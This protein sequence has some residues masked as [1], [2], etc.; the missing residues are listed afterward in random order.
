MAAEFFR[1]TLERALRMEAHT[2]RAHFRLPFAKGKIQGTPCMRIHISV[3]RATVKYFSNSFVFKTEIEKEGL[4]EIARLAWA[5]EVPSSNLGAPTKSI[6]FVLHYLE[7]HIFLL[8]LLWISRRQESVFANHS[9]SITSLHC[10]QART[11]KGRSAIKKLLNSLSLK[12]CHEV[13][14][15]KTGGDLVHFSY[16]ILVKDKSMVTRYEVQSAPPFLPL[17]SCPL[18]V[19]GFQPFG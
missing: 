12:G 11:Q 6:L 16:I 4:Q 10:A 15:G 8:Q 14:E 2:A 17:L 7:S 1:A 18:G 3:H 13:D 19:R 5:Q 9:I